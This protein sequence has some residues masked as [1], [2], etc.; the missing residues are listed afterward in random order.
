MKILLI[1]DDPD[2][3]KFLQRFLGQAGF[4][5]LAAEDGEQGFNLLLEHAADIS[6]VI[7]DV[8]MPNLNG[9]QLC[10][11]IRADTRFE[12]LPFI[13]VSAHTNLEEKL[14]GY[15]VGGDEYIGK[16]LQ[17]E[18]VIIKVKNIVD[19]KIQ[20]ES[21]NK[22]VSDSFNAAM[23]AMTYSSHLGQILQFLQEAVHCT[24]F[25]QLADSI[26]NTTN[27]FGL[28][29]TIQFYTRNNA[30]SFRPQ[31]NVTPLEEN[32]IELS[33][34]KGR[35]FDFSA[36]TVINY[37]DFSLLVKNMPLDDAEK[38]GA[39]KDILGNFCN[40]IEAAT[41]IILS[42]NETQ[43]KNQTMAS[44]NA[45]LEAIERT[46]TSVQRETAMVIEDMMTD[47]DE[48]MLTLGLT[49]NQEDQVRFITQT[50]LE[51]SKNVFKKGLE[52]HKSF[53]QVHDALNSELH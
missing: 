41:K 22:Q 34:K 35:F 30:Q 7:S 27:S 13:F 17:A 3:Q 48:A 47:V 10:E 36:R 21:L 18:E 11:K 50:C 29:T 8:E 49:N 39:I 33:R 24:T 51:K 31:G 9:Y 26:F 15:E 20:H 38:Y 45:A 25:T 53:D 43:H 16:P 32:V 42:R 46:L 23:Q 6:A 1:D 52:L 12:K 37:E 28:N 44:V 2:L 4:E 19:N 5:V 14:K 40:A